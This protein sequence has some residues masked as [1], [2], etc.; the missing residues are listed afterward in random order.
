MN[1]KKIQGGAGIREKIKGK[2]SGV[3]GAS[4]TSESVCTLFV[5]QFHS[6]YLF[7]CDVSVYG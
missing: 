1:K 7:N 6:L 2:T 4:S 3:E 5:V